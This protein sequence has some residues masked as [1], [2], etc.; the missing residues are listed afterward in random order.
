MVVGQN[1][2]EAQNELIPRKSSNG[3]YGFIDKSESFIISPKFDKAF[4]FK[5]GKAKIITNGKWG[6]INIDGEYIVKPK[7]NYIGWSN[8]G[9]YQWNKNNLSLSNNLIPPKKIF[10]HDENGLLAYLKDKHWGLISASGRLFKNEWDSLEYGQ[11]GHFAVYR[12]DKNW[13]WIDINNK[14]PKEQYYDEVIPLS[15]ALIAAKNSS[16]RAYKLFNYEG[17]IQSDS[18][19]RIVESLNSEYIKVKNQMLWYQLDSRANPIDENGYEEIR[20]VIG[21]NTMQYLPSSPWIESDADF[22]TNKNLNFEIK[23]E[24][25]D[26]LFIIEE[27]PNY[28]IWNC[29]SLKKFNISDGDSIVFS[30][31]YVK[32]YHSKAP[33]FQLL[34]KTLNILSDDILDYKTINES[35]LILYKTK[36]EKWTLRDLSA[37]SAIV[38]NIDSSFFK[39]SEN[40]IKLCRSGK[41]GTFD[42]VNK[43]WILDP[44]Y[45]NVIK[46]NDTLNCSLDSDSIKFFG[47]TGF[48]NSMGQIDSVISVNDSVIAL[49]NK[50]NKWT[51]HNLKLNKIINE[52][53]Q[54]ISI[55]GPFSIILKKQSAWVLYNSDNWKKILLN[56]YDSIS[57]FQNGYFVI[58]KNSKLGIIDTNGNFTFQLSDY[59]NDLYSYDTKRWQVYRNGLSGI[60]DHNGVLKISTQFENFD[61]QVFNYIPFKFRSKWGLLD[62]KERFILQPLNDSLEVLSENFVQVW[63]N[64]LTGIKN[65]NDKTLIPIEFQAIIPT[66]FGSFIVKKSDKYGY[67]DENAQQIR[68]VSYDEIKQLDVDLIALKKNDYWQ[69][70]NSKG[71]LVIDKKFAAIYKCNDRLFYK[72]KK[73]WIMK[74]LD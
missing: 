41:Y 24:L 72:E 9:Y 17:T 34:S 44:V 1:I 56:S 27:G 38:S 62:Q 45:K 6:L 19:Y 10:Y 23:N 21:N 14:A 71:E 68:P 58:K 8:D 50:S 64:Q 7:L 55:N 32:I 63:K 66:K 47:K 60:V 35:N 59:Y 49:K 15:N 13:T 5:V 4:S 48:L 73:A 54:D 22:K 20:Y 61:S 18:V 46:I 57:S 11:G 42:L 31:P 40:E 52:E 67:Y 74:S 3:K 43:K 12:N 30:K 69:L 51:L 65:L 33:Q 2:L 28:F 29:K 53:F 70:I 25:A 36:N 26:D 39:F 37:N 16:E